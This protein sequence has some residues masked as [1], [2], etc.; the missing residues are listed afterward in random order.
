LMGDRDKYRRAYHWA[1]HG[2]S[3]LLE[4][5]PGVGDMSHDGH[6]GGT[7]S[8]LWY[9]LQGNIQPGHFFPPVW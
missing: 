8:H 3:D 5:V 9:V 2:D 6:G 4:D 7:S 1:N